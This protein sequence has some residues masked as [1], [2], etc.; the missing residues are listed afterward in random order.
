MSIHI[1]S[2]K[3]ENQITDLNKN[4]SMSNNQTSS[5]LIYKKKFEFYNNSSGLGSSSSGSSGNTSGSQVV[6]DVKR[7]DLNENDYY[8]NCYKKKNILNYNN[9]SVKKSENQ[10]AESKETAT[11][12]GNECLNDDL[13]ISYSDDAG[14]CGTNRKDSGLSSDLTLPCSERGEQDAQSDLLNKETENNFEEENNDKLSKLP[15]NPHS[16]SENVLHRHSIAVLSENDF[17]FNNNKVSYYILFLEYMILISA[18][19]NV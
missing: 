15:I 4:N 18:K 19:K 16:N 13:L 6:D 7:H 3:N 9:S 11:T 17:D 2:Y 10:A 14:S 8:Y 12:E 5:E 1:K